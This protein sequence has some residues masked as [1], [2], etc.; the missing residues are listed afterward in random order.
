MGTRILIF[1]RLLA[2][3]FSQ[4]INVIL[5]GFIYVNI[6][7]T[8]PDPDETFSAFL[9]RKTLEGSKLSKRLAF[10]VDVIMWPLE[11]GMWGH[12]YK[13]AILHSERCP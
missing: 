1:I 8:P 6:G 13:A 2:T 4:L 7:G 9:G 3:A 12:C 10:I 11:G 5:C